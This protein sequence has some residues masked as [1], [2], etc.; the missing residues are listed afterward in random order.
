MAE[1]YGGK[2]SPGQKNGPATGKPAPASREERRTFWMFLAAIP[3]ALKAFWQEPVGL[4]LNLAAFATLVLAAWL[5]REGVRAAKAYAARRSARRPAIP[6]KLMATALTGGGLF[7]GAF[8]SG[9]ALPSAILLGVLGSMLHVFAFGTDPFTDKGMEDIDPFQQDRA[10]RVIAE[11]ETH[12]K[13]MK[14]AADRIGDRNITARVDRFMN[15]ARTMF[16]TVEDDPRDLTAAR[17]YLGV[18]LMGARDATIKFAD[19]WNRSKDQRA[20]ADYEALLNDLETNFD[21]R[22]KLLLSDE[23]TD[24]DIE[25]DVLRDRLNREGLKTEQ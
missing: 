17:K 3:F 9:G 22:T 23:K 6:R 24:L 8:A 16:R 15:T 10:A 2:Y 1:Q 7:M 5:T 19:I 21:A 11:G 13:A 18:Y 20:R 14:A 4:A 25:I 12:L